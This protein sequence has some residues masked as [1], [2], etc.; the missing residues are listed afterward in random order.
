MG[1]DDLLDDVQPQP[2]SPRLGGVEGIKNPE[3]LL[4]RYAMSPAMYLKLHLRRLTLPGQRRRSRTMASTG[5]TES[6]CVS[7]KRETEP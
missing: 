4:G 5:E 6:C 2:C 1:G 7:K 3:Q